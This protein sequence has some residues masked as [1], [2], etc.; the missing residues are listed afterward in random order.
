MP[1]RNLTSTRLFYIINLP[2]TLHETRD[3]FRASTV[4]EDAQLGVKM[5]N[6]VD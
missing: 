2:S 1:I 5:D 3:E 6:R 4:R